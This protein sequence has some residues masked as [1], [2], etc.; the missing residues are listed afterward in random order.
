MW[1]TSSPSLV[2]QAERTH[3]SAMLAAR[4]A[5]APEAVF[6]EVKTDA[7]GWAPITL[8]DFHAQVQA[9]AKGLI[10]SGVSAGER[11]GIMADTRYEWAVMDFAALAAG[12]VTVPIYPSSSAQQVAWVMA[13]ANITWV[14]TDSGERADLVRQSHGTSIALDNLAALEQSGRAVT[15]AQ[16][17]SRTASVGPD[18][19]ATIIYTSGTTG[20]PKGAMLSHANFVEH[21]LNIERDSEFGGIVAGDA[22]L[23]LF[24]PLAHVFG[25]LALVLALSSRT[26]VGFAPSHKTLADDLATFRPTVMV[27]VPRVLETVYNRADAAQHGVKK[28]VFRWAA[29]VARAVAAARESGSVGVMLR[30][31]HRVADQLV[32]AKIRRLLGGRLAYALCG[33]AR[34]DEEVG[35]FFEGVGVT[36]MQGYG[37]T[38]TTAAA[39]GTPEPRRVMGTVGHPIAGCE[40]ALADDGEILLRGANLFMGYWNQPD[41]TAEVM[42]EDWFATGDLGQVVTGRGGE[43][44]SIVGRKKDIVVLSSGKNVQPAVLEDAMRSH[45]AIQDTVVV[46]EGRH[47]VSVLMALDEAMLPGWLHAHS[48]PAMS[49]EEAS[50]DSRVRELVSRAVEHANS[51]VSRAESIREFR[52]VPR[53]F[54]EAREEL[55]A[56]LKVRRANVLANY[57]ALVEEIYARAVPAGA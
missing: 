52:I 26:V 25:R 14:A 23:L 7:G 43:A 45:P 29:R 1:T 28:H 36:V 21:C 55:T 15:D 51:L 13:D 27:L 56:S 11:V 31:K 42:R 8:A 41:A 35:R 40:M 22:R 50:Q 4:A 20:R 16:L 24:L 39:L 33:G 2:A 19:L 5:A 6:A 3:L 53:A 12:A 46:G 10:A 9:V 32:L 44:V 17:Q 37:L 18:D 34:L 49:V 30:L 38:E 47:F 48:L 57:A 54:S